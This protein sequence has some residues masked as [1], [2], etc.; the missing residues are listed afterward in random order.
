MDG[1]LGGCFH[2]WTVVFEYGRLVVMLVLV[3]VVVFMVLVVVVAMVRCW[4]YGC[5]I[6]HGE[7]APAMGV[8]ERREG[9][10]N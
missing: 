5:H 9:D 4:W 3:V 8:N 1:R 2:S 6:T 7:V 10:V